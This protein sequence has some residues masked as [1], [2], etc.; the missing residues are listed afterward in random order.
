MHPSS[1]AYIEYK[2]LYTFLLILDGELLEGKISHLCLH[3]AQY[4]EYV[5]CSTIS[6]YLA[7]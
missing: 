1:E 6:K 2:N 7:K 4:V 5:I 3:S